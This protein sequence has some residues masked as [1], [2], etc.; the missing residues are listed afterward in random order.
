M[1]H[2][3]AFVLPPLVGTQG[4]LYKDEQLVRYT[5]WRTGGNADYVYVPAGL[6]DLVLFLKQ[7][8]QSVPLTWLGLGSNTLVRDGGIAGVVVIMQGAL[9]SLALTPDCTIRAEAGVSSAQLAR[10]SARLG[11]KGLEFMAGIPGTVGGALAMNAGC[12]GGETW[13]H[14]QRVET[15]DRQGVVKVRPVADFVVH[16][17]HVVRPLEEWFVAGHFSFVE[18]EKEASLELIR[19]LLRKRN[20]TQPTGTANCGSVF[21]NPPGDFAAR[22][23]EACGLKG[24]QVGGAS[25]SQKHANFILNDN[26]ATASDIEQLIALVRDAVAQKTGVELVPEVCIMGRP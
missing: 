22:L 19:Q 12:F 3:N 21:R 7:L 2:H 20:Q 15:I 25:V 9:T 18:G 1:V 6:A 14:V 24:K 16:Y 8:P 5:S 10:Q 11:A 17:R 13:Q 4:Q 23:I 26:A